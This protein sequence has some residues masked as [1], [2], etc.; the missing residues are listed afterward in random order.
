MHLPDRLGSNWTFGD[1]GRAQEDK[2]YWYPHLTHDESL[3]FATY[4]RLKWHD[5]LQTQYH[6]ARMV[7]HS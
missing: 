3:V 2:W 4:D 7:F 6:H 5:E 1:E